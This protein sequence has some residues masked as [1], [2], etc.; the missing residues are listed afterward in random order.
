MASFN[1]G[2]SRDKGSGSGSGSSRHRVVFG[3]TLEIVSY[4]ATYVNYEF[5]F[6]AKN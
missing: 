6:I 3:S 5:L 1:S 2:R 4:V